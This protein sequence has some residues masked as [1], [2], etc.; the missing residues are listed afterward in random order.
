MKMKA[1]MFLILVL[2][3]A[4]VVAGLT[5]FAPNAL[6]KD[7]GKKVEIGNHSLMGMYEFHADGLL[8]IEGVPP[9]GMWETGRFEADGK[10]N[11]TN[12]VE[13]SNMLSSSDERIIDQPFTFTGTYVVNPD[14]TAKATVDVY[15]PASGITIKKTLWFV[16][17]SVD[18]KGIAHGFSGGHADAILGEGVHGNASSH[19]GSKIDLYANDD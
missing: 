5:G 18:K 8:E 6:A 10:G 3:I 1:L 7:Q 19:V 12:G 16:L 17:H 2:G 9:R 13:Y 15:V 11:I 14:A 4:L